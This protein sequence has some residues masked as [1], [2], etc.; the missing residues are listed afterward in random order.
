[1]EHPI[2]FITLLFEK[3]GL[4]HF[5]HEWPWV[6]NSWLIMLLLIISGKIA[7]SSIKMI[8]G[9]AQ[10]F[11]EV[12]IEGIE[13]FM[14]DVM[15]EEG[16]A[17]FPLI[18]TLFLYIFCCNCIGLIPG[19]FSPTASLNTTLSMALIVFVLTHIIGIKNHG[20]H[21][22]KHF[23]GP[24]W[25][26]IPLMVP[27]EIVGHLARVLSLTFRLF[28]NIMAEDLVL[29]ILMILAGQF[30]APL[31]MFFLFIFADFVQAFIFSMLTMM[32]FAGAMEEAH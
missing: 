14:V 11:F 24:V 2:I 6:T 21:Y 29:A 18:A 9:G 7:T 25:W 32:Y 28:G 1:M 3:I 27:I 8:P 22:I 15:G 30:L 10:S 13:N 23:C 5:A 16:R 26:L 4:G 19:F 31:P 12:V 17:M 20:T